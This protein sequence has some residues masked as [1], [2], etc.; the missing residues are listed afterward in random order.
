[1]ATKFRLGPCVLKTPSGK[2]KGTLVYIDEDT[3][4]VSGRRPYLV[5]TR[6]RDGKQSQFVAAEDIIMYKP[7]SV[8]DCGVVA[9]AP[10][11]NMKITNIYGEHRIIVGMCATGDILS[12]TLSA[13]LKVIGPKTTLELFEDHYYTDGEPFGKRIGE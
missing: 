1:M 7:W 13:G 11:I 12:I 8:A 5:V 3:I 2:E 4:N 6:L 9:R 10:H